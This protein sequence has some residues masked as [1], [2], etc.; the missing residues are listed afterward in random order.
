M[1][2]SDGNPEAPTD[3]KGRAMMKHK[4]NLDVLNGLLAARPN[5][6]CPRWFMTFG[7]IE[8]SGQDS[9]AWPWAGK[10][11]DAKFRH[12]QAEQRRLELEAQERPAAEKLKAEN[13]RRRKQEEAER[14]EAERQAR[15]QAEAEALARRLEAAAALAAS[16]DAATLE[17]AF[18][19]R[20]L[21]QV[22]GAIPDHTADAIWTEWKLNDPLLASNAD[23]AQ[24]KTKL[25]A[26]LVAA[27]KALVDGRAAA[28]QSLEAAATARLQPFKSKPGQKGSPKG[29]AARYI[30]AYGRDARQLMTTYESAVSK[31]IYDARD[32]QLAP[33]QQ[34]SEATCAVWNSFKTAKVRP[35]MHLLSRAN[36]DIDESHKELYETYMEVHDQCVAKLVPE[37]VES[38]SCCYKTHRVLGSLS[39]TTNENGLG[40]EP[41]PAVQ[42]VL[43]GI[44]KAWKSRVLSNK[45]KWPCAHW[46]KKWEEAGYYCD[47]IMD[48]SGLDGE[49]FT[50]G[51]AS[52]RLPEM[53]HWTCEAEGARSQSPSRSR[54]LQLLKQH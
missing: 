51:P 1:N 41:I 9:S 46:Q 6:L 48:L 35:A 37:G 45:A 20:S 14:L 39:A 33:Q 21:D 22:D 54:F 5:S 29:D 49:S 40:D 23:H 52:Y 26:C 8:Y 42:L 28:K 24:A 25:G 38:K 44:F 53:A 32:S 17:T 10:A 16:E 4:R 13:E 3:S 2:P 27:K 50:A 11:Y 15:L 19:V 34:I 36:L 18:D 47:C 30:L 7:D 43:Q 31:C 12:E